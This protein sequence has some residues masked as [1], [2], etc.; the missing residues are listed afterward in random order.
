MERF[1]KT[2]CKPWT[3]TQHVGIYLFCLSVQTALCLNEI[4]LLDPPEEA[5]PDSRLDVF[6][7]C[8]QPATVQL[9]LIVFLDTGRARA[10][11]LNHWRCDPHG[12]SLK[13]VRLN[14]PDWLVYRADGIV[15]ESQWVQSCML[16][17]AVTFPHIFS[18]AEELVADSDVAFLKPIP[19]FNRPVKRHQLCITWSMLML[20]LTP[21]FLLK[22]CP[23][24]QETVQLLSSIFA[25]TG[26]N[27]GIT[28]KLDPF[29]N[30]ALEFLRFKAI[31]SPWCMFS[32]W[33]L[34][35]RHCQGKLCGLFHHTDSQNNYISPS[36]FLTN[37][38]QLHI[39]ISGRSK[40][41]PAFLSPFK[42]HLREWCRIN[43][44][45]LAERVT[46]SVVCIDNEQRTDY[47]VEYMLGHDIMLNDTQG[48]F[49]IGGGK[50]IKGVEG[51]YGPVVY[52]RNRV[53]PQSTSE[54]VLPEVVR[55]V[56]LTGWLQTCQAFRLEMNAKISEYSH[57][58]QQGKE[59]DTCF[60]VYHEWRVKE[61][62][63]SESQCELWE[64]TLP[65]RGRAVKLVKI[66][67]F[68]HG[69]RGLS[70]T[71]VG[72]ALYSLSLHK[73]HRG[74][75]TGAVST[76]LPLLL[77]AG[78]LAD[79]RALHMASVLYSSGL[80]I[81]KQTYKSWLLALLAAQKDDRLALLHLGHLHHQGLHGFPADPALAYA[82]YANIAI[83]TA[84]RRYPTPEQMVLGL[85]EI[86]LLNPPEEALPDNLLYVFYSCK[87]PATVQLDLIVVFDTGLSEILRLNHWRCD[88]FDPTIKAVRLN[89]PDWLL[90]QADEIVPDSQWVQSCT[91]EAAVTYPV[92]DD[93][94]ELVAAADEAALEPVP[95]FDRPVK[96]HRL[97][98]SWSM[99]M[100]R[101]TPGFVEKQCPFEQE[102][103]Q[104]L[105]SIFASTGEKFG[106][107]TTLDPYSDNGLEYLRVKAIP[108]PWCMFSV[109]ILVTRHCQEEICGLFHHIDSQN[110]YISPTLFLRNSGKLHIQ[111]N[112]WSEESSAFLTSFKVPLRKWCR[113]SFMMLIKRVTVNMVCIDN[114]QKT[115]YSTNYIFAHDVVMDDTEGYF[116]IGG[117]KYI[118]GVEGFYG[119]V[120][121]YRNR[122]VHQSPSE[123]V[124]PDVV[125]AV[126]LAGWLQTCQEFHLEMSAKI[127]GYTHQARRREESDIY[128]DTFHKWIVKERQPSEPQCE[129]WE[130]TLPQRR[131]AVKLVKMLAFKHGG[132]GLSLAAMGRALYSLSLHKLHKGS[133]TGAVSTILPLLL[134]AGCLA[135]N[136]A[137]HMASVLYS[138]GLGVKKQTYKSWLLALLAAQK[139]DRLA[140]LHLGH[141]HHQG[142]H[143]LP[144]DTALA[145]AYYANIAT[146]TTLDRLNP[147]PEQTFVEA[148][149]LNNDEV[150]NLQTDKDH[151][152]FQWLKLQARRGA[153]EAEQAIG[154]MLFW[155]QQ[156]VSPN[157]QE[158]V[159]HYERGAVRWEDPASMYD[160]GIVLLQ[161]QGVEK[162]VPK[163]VRFLKKAMDKNFVPAINALAW[164]YEQHEKDYEKAVKLW[165]QADLLKSPDAALNLGVV[166]SQG[167]YPGKAA[168]KFM[169]YQY[170][171]KSAQRGHIRGAVQ[172]A[173]IWTTGIPGHVDRRPSDAVL[174][175][176]WAAEHNG[177]LG[178]ILRRALD[179]YLKNDMFHSLLYYMVAA[180]CG[181]A[182]AQFNVAYLCEQNKFFSILDPALASSCM[183]RYYNLTVQNENPDPYALIRMGDLLY[184]GQ[185]DMPGDLFSAAKMYSHAALRKEPQG[186]YNLGLLVA[187][188]YRL[189]LSVLINLGLSELYLQDNITLQS[190]LYERCRD[191]ED[192][193][194]FFPC[195]L[196]LYNVYFQTFQ[197]DYHTAVKVSTAAAIV[198]ASTMIV[199]IPISL[200]RLMLSLN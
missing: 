33:V 87:G 100:L 52:H 29:S 15:P 9:D 166:Y 58:A 7:S 141:L 76:I 67:A 92:L 182:P 111:M 24:E 35:T 112:G 178:S 49:V 54:V 71:A 38:G 105:S 132:R 107:T 172:L 86:M 128:V 109:W 193:D 162:D 11:R 196:A 137:L 131:Q 146:Q 77:Q 188:G 133:R 55:A 45:L 16:E 39:Q 183:W 95:Y 175:V 1:M 47:S 3:S 53:V 99:D 27:F 136:R 79:N 153:T 200:R 90:Y 161:G 37:S 142:L 191:S 59:S 140:L 42:V 190:T 48:H 145:Y 198:A 187:E 62:Q 85:D 103:V 181:Y 98:N 180:E 83:Q 18:D 13:T 138:S 50:Y 57:Q 197:N 93:D 169:A 5:L 17:A 23:L 82:Y 127:S 51:F 149:Y 81:K 139:D 126:N 150:L 116:V 195:S 185:A 192:T 78:C 170:Y 135:D 194:G 186:W 12:P 125:R 157:I 102:T 124:I 147:T 168:D 91:L 68:K 156:G 154:R 199:I 44:M 70:L 63:P 115:D 72:R 10:F 75:G 30:K 8:S 73:L 40:K 179:S 61:R 184:E 97:C 56:N 171:L 120:V 101:L 96:R 148:V 22:Q 176:K 36:L 106:I 129:L 164:Y 43:V 119:P 19:Y 122:V 151:H 143:G 41:S 26:E 121:Y 74:N 20:Q 34:V 14:L 152:I 130:E 60:D 144:A 173:D 174:W 66:L 163:A 65:Q 4:I 165:E 32:M 28:K 123:V 177:Y 94:E 114:E 25:S 118:K 155:G 158:A 21:G 110:N 117:G 160:Y 108:S 89:L 2:L 80:G 84:V 113:I 167:L 104:L 134:Q 31:S 64:E 6:Y 69:G 46:V 88:P 189:P 159:R